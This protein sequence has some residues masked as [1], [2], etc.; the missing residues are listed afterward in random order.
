MRS[1][2]PFLLILVL[3]I[4]AGSVVSC[5]PLSGRGELVRCS[6]GG[7]RVWLTDDGSFDLTL[8][9]HVSRA[10]R[11][12]SEYVI[13]KSDYSTLRLIRHKD[14]VLVANGD[15]IF[16]AYD[17]ASDRIIRY[18]DLPF[19]IWEGQGEVLDSYQWSDGPA[20]MRDGFPERRE[21]GR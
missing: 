21:G 4:V 14:R 6:I 17:P 11:T 16:A 8:Q 1:T 5:D 18:R 10:G 19:T 3:L 12:R 13:D 7:S 9:L 15:Y 2:F 20:R